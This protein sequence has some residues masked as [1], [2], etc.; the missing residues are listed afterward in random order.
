MNQY[1][2]DTH[3]LF[4]YLTASPR[5]GRAAKA[6]FDEAA[7]GEAMIHL[8]VVVLAE[9]YFLNDKAGRPLDFAAEFERLRQAGQFTMVPFIPEDILDFRDDAPVGE[10]HDRM[11]VGVA[12]RLGAICLSKDADIIASRHVPVRWE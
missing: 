8:P 9:L 7:A 12:R 6:A 1:V 3:A 10:M 11:I 2:A 5:L 4:W